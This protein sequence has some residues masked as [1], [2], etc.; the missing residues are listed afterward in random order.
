MLFCMSDTDPA[1]GGRSDWLRAIEPECDGEAH[2]LESRTA[3]W[4]ERLKLT[5]KPSD[6]T[7]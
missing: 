1:V 4:D 7:G 2:M 5:K 6:F 3:G